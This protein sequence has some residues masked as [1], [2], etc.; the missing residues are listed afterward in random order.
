MPTEITLDAT[1]TLKRQVSLQQEAYVERKLT[2]NLV[3]FPQEFSIE[4][5]VKDFLVFRR[6]IVHFPLLSEQYVTFQKL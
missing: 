5:S 4:K 6:M 3:C 1:F 2:D